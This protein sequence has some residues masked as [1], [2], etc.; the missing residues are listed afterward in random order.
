MFDNDIDITST[1]CYLT[2]VRLENNKSYQLFHRLALVASRMINL[3][4]L[5]DLCTN[6]GEAWQASEHLRLIT[7]IGDQNNNAHSKDNL[8]KFINWNLV[9]S[10]YVI[11]KTSGQCYLRAKEW[12]LRVTQCIFT[13]RTGKQHYQHFRCKCIVQ[14]LEGDMVVIFNTIF[15]KLKNTATLL[16]VV[17]TV[18]IM[19]MQHPMGKSAWRAALKMDNGTGILLGFFNSELDAAH[20]SDTCVRSQFGDLGSSFI[21]FGNGSKDEVEARKAKSKILKHWAQCDKCS[22]WRVLSTEWTQHEFQCFDVLKSCADE[23]DTENTVPA[24][25]CKNPRR[26]Y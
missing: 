18:L 12:Y 26:S 7:S 19:C 3:S 13:W 17:T 15:P 5:S 2:F 20:V 11:T 24:R 22:K 16:K 21:N 1:E 23:E 10:S 9:S 6:D 8:S 25:T 4:K 14:S